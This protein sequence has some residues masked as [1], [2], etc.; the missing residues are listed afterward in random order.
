MNIFKLN[1]TDYFFEV[2]N[3]SISEFYPYRNGFFLIDTDGNNH[4]LK[5]SNEDPKDLERYVNYYNKL[6][7][8]FPNACE[9]RKTINGKISYNN[10]HLLS[11]PN[12]VKVNINEKAHKEELISTFKKYF[13]VCHNSPIGFLKEDNFIDNFLK[14]KLF[15]E[16]KYFEI[17]NKI[18]KNNIE[19]IFI[20][21]Y[22][23]LHEVLNQNI[24]N[25]INLYT[26][27]FVNSYPKNIQYFDIDN[28][29]FS[30]SNGEIYFV[31]FS[32]PKNELRSISFLKIIK[33]FNW[34][35]DDFINS[36]KPRI[37]NLEIEFIKLY[38]SL[39][40]EFM[41]KYLKY[42]NGNYVNEKDFEKISIEA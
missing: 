18:F 11:F 36:M 30:Y 29:Y 14:N 5:T 13:N 10:F 20:R 23:K 22:Y 17:S 26:E 1:F 42:F 21:N 33:R 9:L 27:L 39:P 4:F 3:V 34:N 25:L 38:L 15:L 16:D 28:M 32:I 35:T 24:E 6:R 7:S 8:Y 31:D 2:W 12:G 19:E 37:F 40:H 41:N